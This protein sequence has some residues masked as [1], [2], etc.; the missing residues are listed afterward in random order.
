[1]QDFHK[2]VLIKEVIAALSKGSKAPLNG[3]YI[4]ATLGH[5]GYTKEI[6]SQ[7]GKALGIEI[8]TE[9]LEVARKRLLA[10]PGALSHTK[11][12]PY[13][14]VNANFKDIDLIAKNNGFD[15]ADGI[16]FDL[17]VNSS[18]LTSE[19]RGLSF[20][21]PDSN[22]DMRFSRMSSETTAA[23]LLNVLREDQ[24]MD[25]FRKVC[26]YKIAKKLSREII[27]TR[28]E[29]PFSKVGDLLSVV[30]SISRTKGKINPA[31]TIFLALRIAVNSEL[32]NISEA[33]PKAMGV[34]RSG[35]RL[36]VISFHSTEDAVVKESFR[37]LVKEGMAFEVNQKPMVPSSKEIKS[38]PRSRS[39]KLRIL[40]KI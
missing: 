17:G 5:A 26:D 35:G 10:C 4:D 34:L 21:Y 13:S 29:K 20:Q 19:E 15:Q 1:M 14:L 8:D 25:M 24:L 31:T 7:G 33:I 3:R 40:E 11:D 2:P 23:D 6:I 28:V 22:L 16:I 32:E 18:Q 37:Y 12:T 27:H 36:L 39:A 9:S 38:N 30:S